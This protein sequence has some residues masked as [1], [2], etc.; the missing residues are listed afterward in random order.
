MQIVSFQINHQQKSNESLFKPAF[1]ERLSKL[2]IES[3]IVW[4][5]KSI[6]LKMWKSSKM[7]WIDSGWKRKSNLSHRMNS[8]TTKKTKCAANESTKMNTQSR[9]IVI[10]FHFDVRWDTANAM[11]LYANIVRCDGHTHIFILCANQ[12]VSI[13]VLQRWI[14]F[15]WHHFSISINSCILRCMLLCGTRALAWQMLCVPF[16]WSFLSSFRLLL[17]GNYRHWL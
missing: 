5:I 6:R 17:V 16:F 7:R 8:R 12:C 11:F 13:C 2:L 15:N 10:E 14:H 9:R 3:E 1:N 4:I